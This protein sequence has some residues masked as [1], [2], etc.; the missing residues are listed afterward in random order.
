MPINDRQSLHCK[1]STIPRI[2]TE[3]KNRLQLQQRNYGARRDL[4]DGRER[5]VLEEWEVAKFR[6]DCCD[7]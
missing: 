1:G 2:G 4:S 6:H 7:Q 5:Q 3:L